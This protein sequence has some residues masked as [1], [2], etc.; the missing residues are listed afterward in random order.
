[1]AEVDKC[2]WCAAQQQVS[3]ESVVARARLL[4]ICQSLPEVT[5]EGEQHITFRV[6]NRTFAYYLNNH[7]NTWRVAVACKAELGE[8]AL[9][10]A[11]AP[12]RYFIPAY[13]GHRGWV[14]LRL[15][16]VDVEWDEVASLVFHSYRPTA[17]KRLVKQLNR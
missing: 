14:G 5:C 10:V 13:L 4:K 2:G 17:P 15:D 9:L 6:C 12:D 8:N 3:M 11:Q 16:G 1:V 7:Q